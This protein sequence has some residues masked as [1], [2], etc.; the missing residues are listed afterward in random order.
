MSRSVNKRPIAV[1][2]AETP[3]FKHGRDDLEPFAW[4]VYDGSERATFWGS[5]CTEQMLDY[6]SD[7]KYL[8]FAHNGGKFDYFFMLKYAEKQT[9]KVINGRISQ[10]KIG[11]NIYRDSWNIIPMPLAG[12][13]KTEIDYALF[14]ADKR[15]LNKSLIIDYLSDDCTYLYDLVKAFCDRFG[16]KLTLAGAAMTELLRTIPP[17]EKFNLFTDGKYRDFYYGGRCEAYQTGHFKHELKVYDIKSAYPYAMTFQHPDPCFNSWSIGTKL[18]DKPP[19]FAT[20]R[21]VS[22]GALPYRDEKTKKLLFPRDNVERVYSVTGWEIQAGLETNTL[23][24]VEVLEVR[25]PDKTRDFSE[26]VEKFFQEKDEGKTE[27]NEGKENNDIEKERDGTIKELFAKLLLNSAYGKF[28]QDALGY[29]EW[30]I[31]EEGDWPEYKENDIEWLKENEINIHD[32]KHNEIEIDEFGR[33]VHKVYTWQYE[34]TPAEGIEMY[35]RPSP[36]TQGF[37]NVAVAASITGFVRAYLW[38]TICASEDFYY[39]DTDSITCKVFG[40]K[41]GK[42]LGDWEHEAT[43]YETF[44]AGKKLYALWTKENESPNF[45]Y[46]DQRDAKKGGWK[47]ASKGVKLTPY[48]MAY[49]IKTGRSVKWDNIAPTFS[50]TH[51]VRYLSR[52]IKS[53]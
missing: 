38:R 25:T 10:M 52:N 6:L 19:Y 34:S 36:N 14:E 46:D 37:Y 31:I 30:Q 11:D 47:M 33:L 48:E 20:I 12:Y 13:K 23:K 18:P 22:L 40:G 8:I 24:I 50:L 49:A 1:I 43:S 35:R 3:P 53:I 17:V 42:E 51:G 29:D 9:I 15:E 5:D 32:P 4:Q 2:D 16:R 45:G 21:A 28:A 27:K 41:E 7:K 26:Y 44:I 39:C